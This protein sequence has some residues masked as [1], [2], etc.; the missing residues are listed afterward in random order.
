MARVT[1]FEC[2]CGLIHNTK[3]Q[4][5]FCFENE[6]FAELLAQGPVDEKDPYG[7]VLSSHVYE[8]IESEIGPVLYRRRLR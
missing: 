3:Q 8:K 1:R 4:A 5:D 2:E 7:K 6:H